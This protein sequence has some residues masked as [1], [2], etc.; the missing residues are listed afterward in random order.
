MR[1]I[2]ILL[3]LISNY[4]LA[5][6]AGINTYSPEVSDLSTQVRIGSEANDDTSKDIILN[7]SDNS[8][9]NL[10]IEE[11][12]E[13]SYEEK[14]SDHDCSDTHQSLLLIREHLTV[15]KEAYVLQT[16]LPS[17]KYLSHSFV[18]LWILIEVY[19]L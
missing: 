7:S 19:R 9:E 5:S 14:E 6:F 17:F 12:L 16:L 15:L 10:F 4:G 3:V 8:S 11:I 13:E 1:A 2:A 18:P